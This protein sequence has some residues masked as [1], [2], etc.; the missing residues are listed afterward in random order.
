M[1]DKY[2]NVHEL[3]PLYFELSILGS[4]SCQVWLNLSLFVLTFLT[5]TLT[6]KVLMTLKLFLL[7][8]LERVILNVYI[9]HHSTFH[10]GTVI[11]EGLQ[12][13]WV[14]MWCPD[15]RVLD[16]LDLMGCRARPKIL[17]KETL[18]PNQMSKNEFQHIS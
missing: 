14:Q 15:F 16:E 9:D 3:I 13:W 2:V 17:L 18:L 11:R 1:L 4:N 5:G 7:L 8:W 6:L 12:L 10:I